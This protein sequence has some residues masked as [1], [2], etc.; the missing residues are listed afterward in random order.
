VA[1]PAEASWSVAVPAGLESYRPQ[2]QLVRSDRDQLWIGRCAWGGAHGGPDGCTLWLYNRL[3]TS[4]MVREAPRQ[5][6]GFEL[7]AI[8]APPGWQVELVDDP[9][10]RV[11]ATGPHKALSCN[12]TIYPPAVDPSYT[13]PTGI[14][15]VRWLATEPPMFMAIGTGQCQEGDE[16]ADC[17]HPIMFEGCAAST[18]YISNDPTPGPDGMFALAVANENATLSYSIHVRGREI[19]RVDAE[20]VYFP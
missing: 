2:W 18:T 19:G 5:A 1:V 4:E 15:S 20:R 11:D 17:P 14:T 9:Y 8:A 10:P 16:S 12:G 7:P 3:G 6:P 13:N